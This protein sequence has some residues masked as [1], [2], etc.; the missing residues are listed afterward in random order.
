MGFPEVM[1]D[2]D[3]VAPADEAPVRMAHERHPPAIR[4]MHWINFPL[5]FV[6]MYSGLRIYWADDA[7]AV[8]IGGWEWFHFFP[9]G[10][11]EFFQLD[12]ALARGIAFH[13]T[14]GWLF[15]LNGL[16]YVVYLAVS[17]EWR[18][19][20]PDRAAW[21]DAGRVVLHDLHLRRDEPPQ[22]RYNAAQQIAYTAVIVMGVV[23]VASG[24][25][26]YKPTQLSLLTALFGG[27]ETARIVHFWTTLLLF[28]FFVVHVLQV[29]RAGW[30]NLLAMITG[31][32]L[33][34]EPPDA[35]AASRPEARA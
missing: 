13:F 10:F 8:G 33:D 9:D 35:P 26:I 17:R 3:T 12:F 19:V 1:S 15:V 4:W 21:R 24:F 7:R 16:A 29:A 14:F 28:G 25:A 32:E 6:M 31:F 2:V 23:I 27:Y 11:Y 30:R 22:G 34:P 20:V 18:H 5:L